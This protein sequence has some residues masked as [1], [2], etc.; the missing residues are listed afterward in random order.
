MVP[1][2]CR[3]S[4]VRPVLQDSIC[5]KG[6]MR[7]AVPRESPG[8]GPTHKGST[9]VETVDSS[10]RDRVLKSNC[11]RKTVSTVF[12]A[13]QS[14]AG[15]RESERRMLWLFPTLDPL[16]TADLRQETKAQFSRK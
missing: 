10:P 9:V 6:R 14:K 1:F 15:T 13:D 11:R 4:L 3:S 8:S 7:M 12:D 5:W 16:K 2:D